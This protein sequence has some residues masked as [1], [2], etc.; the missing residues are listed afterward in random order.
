MKTAYAI[1]NP[2]PAAAYKMALA[3]SLGLGLAAP[4]AAAPVKADP[5]PDL[6]GVYGRD[7]HSYP[8]PYMKGRAIADGYD[9]AYLKPWVVEALT[10]DDLVTKSG[11]AVI[12]AHSDLLSRRR[13]PMSSAAR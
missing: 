6:T 10:R 5:A 3:L 12:T 9:N 1:R 13:T 11:H 7:A 4:M 8:K 2:K